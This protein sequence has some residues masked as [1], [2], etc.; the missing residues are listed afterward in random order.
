MTISLPTS[1]AGQAA[2]I[3]RPGRLTPV[4]RAG[5]VH[6]IPL[7]TSEIGA[8]GFL[9]GL[10]TIPPKGAIALHRHNCPESVVILDG[11]AVAQIDS[12]EHALTAHDTT[13]VPAHVPHRVANPSS[14]SPL[15]I[16]W[17]YGATD[18]TR[19]PA[20]GAPTSR[21]DE[22]L[23]TSSL[24]G[25]LIEETTTFVVVPGRDDDLRAVLESARADL[26]RMTRVLS[27]ELRESLT[28]PHRY[29]VVTRWRGPSGSGSWYDSEA[30]APWRA[31]LLPLLVETPEV[32]HSVRAWLAF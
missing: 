13:F 25:P 10:T 21:I 3:M 24:S 32:E 16:L 14:T 17:I 5:G 8:G 30:F 19:I 1:T 4:A 6:T 27:V 11:D 29:V 2:T 7:V 9:S 28:Q 15:T 22:E 23:G 12:D 26:Q 20:D 18:A 31:R